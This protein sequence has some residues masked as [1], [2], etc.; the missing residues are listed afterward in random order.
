MEGLEVIV[1]VWVQAGQMKYEEGNDGE[2]IVEPLSGLVRDETARK[3][4]TI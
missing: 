4:R 3:P 2:E 1:D